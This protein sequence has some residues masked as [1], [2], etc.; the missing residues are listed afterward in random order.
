MRQALTLVQALCICSAAVAV[1]AQADPLSLGAAVGFSTTPYR[2]HDT[3]VLPLPVINYE[4]ERFFV[5]GLSAGVFALKEQG[6]EVF[7]D[8]SYMPLNFDPDDNSNWRMKRLDSRDSTAM[9][10][11]GYR[12]KDTW[13]VVGVH[14][15]VDVLGNSD[16]ILAEATYQ[17]PFKVD[18]W[19]FVPGLGVM[20]ASGNHN[21]YY[22]GVSNGEAAR[23]GLSAYKA[24]DSL[25]PY[26]QM[27]AGY[28]FTPN[29][30][31]FANGRIDFLSKEVR[32]SPMVD[33]DYTGALS[34]GV[35]YSF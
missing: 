23:S 6:H 29:W 33:S 19:T 20:W 2:D 4:G 1:S 28:A 5:R 11:G 10:G 3:Q 9:V 27:S 24:N 35:K 31:A 25:S 8:I 16:G 32:N 15:A 30:S 34:V 17:Y 21:D 18:S 22:F 26:L 13:G 14:A 7:A 12:Y